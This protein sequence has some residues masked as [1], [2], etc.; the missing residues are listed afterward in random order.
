MHFSA[1]VL[2]DGDVDAKG[3]DVPD[4]VCTAIEACPALR[5]KAQNVKAWK[6]GDKSLAPRTT[7]RRI[8]TDDQELTWPIEGNIPT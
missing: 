6:T 4:S 5:W 3:L 8:S 2:D 1:R 7:R